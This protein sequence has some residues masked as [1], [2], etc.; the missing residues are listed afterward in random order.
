[1]KSIRII[2]LLLS[3]NKS[4]ECASVFQS[5]H[6]F[7]VVYWAWSLFRLFCLMNILRTKNF[8]A[9]RWPSKPLPCLLQSPLFF[10]LSQYWAQFIFTSSLTSFTDPAEEKPPHSIM[11]PPLFSD[12]C[13][14]SF[15]RTWPVTFRPKS[16]IYSYLGLQ[17]QLSLP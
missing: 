15:C 2:C 13:M 9:W 12:W 1:M 3:K 4:G 10:M 14:L 16:C 8:Y 11:Q 5:C 17:Q 7:S 6:L